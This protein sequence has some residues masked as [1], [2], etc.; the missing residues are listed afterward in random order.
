M[1]PGSSM[2][3]FHACLQN[4][5]WN[6]MT[7]PGVG[8]GTRWMSLPLHT[9]QWVGRRGVQ[10]GLSMPFG[11]VGDAD[12]S[13]ASLRG[14]GQMAGEGVRAMAR[15]GGARIGR[16]T[17]TEAGSTARAARHAA[18]EPDESAGAAVSGRGP[19][20]AGARRGESGCIGGMG[21]RGA[22]ARGAAGADA[23]LPGCPGSWYCARPTRMS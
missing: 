12:G 5:Q 11:S 16:R 2:R 21:S 10:G 23:S 17:A 9:G 18:S 19:G 13:A 8:F 6:Q 4:R 15:G 14:S 3:N 20:K 22:H 1:F 7:A